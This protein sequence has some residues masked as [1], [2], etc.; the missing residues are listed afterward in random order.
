MLKRFI[1]GL[2]HFTVYAVG[3]IVLLAAVTVT[4]IRLVLPDIGEYR[5]EV[6]AWVSHYMG[7]P[8]VIHSMQAS[9]Q[10]WQP[11]LH[12]EDI[13]L[14]NKAGTRTITHFESAQVN[15]DPIATLLKRQF[16]PR[17]LMVSG[18]E[19]SVTRLEN[20][21]IYIQ[22][23]NIQNEETKT[24]DKNELAEWLFKQKKIELQNAQIEWVDFKH[25]QAPLLLSNVSFTLKTDA[26]RIQLE[27]STNLPAKYGKRMDF[28]FDAYGDLL[29][30]EWSGELYLSAKNINPDGWYKN[31]R[32]FDINIAGGKADLQVWSTWERAKLKQLEG[33][34]NY[35]DFATL[36]KNTSLHVEELSYGFGGERSSDDS[37][38]FSV[39]MDKFITEN[40]SWPQTELFVSTE[41]IQSKEIFKLDLSF[42]YLK[43]DDLTP[44]VSSLSLLPESM[45]KHLGDILI[46]GNLRNGRISFD[47]ERSKANK[48]LFELGFEELAAKVDTKLPSFSGLSGKIRGNLNEG[49]LTLNDTDSSEFSFFSSKK[50]TLKFAELDG[51]IS[52]KKHDIDWT[53]S[54][55]LLKLKLGDLSLRLTGRMWGQ[56]K[57]SAIVDLVAE[58]DPVLLEKIPTYL[59]DSNRFK[60]KQW[61]ERSILG[62]ELTSAGAIVRGRLS[63]FPFENHEGQFKAIAN[64]S[65]GV[66]EYSKQWPVVDNIDA[67]VIFAG[68]QMSGKFQHAKVFNADVVK[69]NAL[70][71]DL[72]VKNKSIVLDGQVK[73]ITKDLSLFIRQSPLTH[74]QMVTQTGD[75]LDKGDI[76]LDLELDI[77]LKRGPKLVGVEGKLR[78]DDAVLKSHLKNLELQAVKGDI[79]FTQNSAHG[80]NLSATFLDQAVTLELTK[81]KE[82]SDK[83]A[84]ISING[85]SDQ[86]FIISR[87]IEHVPTMKSREKWLADRLSGETDWQFTLNYEKNEGDD[88]LVNS[89][90]IRSNLLGLAIDLPEPVGKANDTSMPINV[91]K[92]LEE[93]VDST[94]VLQYGA[95]VACDFSFDR[96]TTTP[97]LQYIHLQLGE[98]KETEVI[99]DSGLLLSGKIERLGF[100]EWWNALKLEQEQQNEDGFLAKNHI[101]IDIETQSLDIFGQTFPDVSIKGKKDLTDWNLNLAAES[102]AGNIQLPAKLQRDKLIRF[103]LDKLYLKRTPSSAEKKPVDPVVVP[104]LQVDVKDFT[105]D[106]RV[107]GEAVLLA[108]PIED[109]LSIDQF[110]FNKPALAIQGKGIWR[111]HSEQHHSSFNIE[112][113]AD[114]MD[115]MLGTFGYDVTAIKKGETDLLI[116]ANWLGSPTDFSLDRLNGTLSMQIKKGQLLDINPSAGRLFGLLSIQTLPRRLSLDFTDLF[117]K[118]LA[119]DKIEGNFE[120]T[121]GNAYTNDLF[122][123]GPSA[124]V[125]ISG[126]TGLSEQDYDQVVTVTP[127]ITGN[128]PVAGALF[129]PVG[130]GLGAILYFASEMF[131]STNSNFGKLLR[132]QYTITGNWHEPVVEKLKTNSKNKSSG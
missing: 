44:L 103:D 100:S 14:L 124:S 109:G 104:S 130:I 26:E 25:Q 10:G 49:I 46:S 88:K 87:I 51:D 93:N 36:V 90:N 50:Q 83:V 73:G 94:L 101:H 64:V 66:L 75:A 4:M 81:S 132:Y 58:A 92:R 98:K 95:D 91:Y 71:P 108:S 82:Q 22:G 89:F 65:G 56:G 21:A 16:I 9:W 131:E 126:R 17:H 40:G 19:L 118:G 28:A 69:A 105:Y 37:W 5:N 127:Q 53:L 121:N 31:Y 107:F 120:I 119:F 123:D 76:T 54:S 39:N 33:N 128:L 116:D 129:G 3:I 6:E 30:S 77:P 27:G 7:F 68:K 74:N 125:A 62:G 86:N 79:H 106:D 8:V 67:E 111:R 35:S 1:K 115:A 96:Q 15:I 12:L 78:L 48:L 29:T 99:V 55:P 13:D 60:I 11:H 70:I 97:A 122:M 32:P 63:D 72:G 38:H 18:F 57:S 24:N 52:W 102:V 85:H 42:N 45:K 61:M 110:S 43:L 112:L 34:L 84:A 23:I 2:Y 41:P 80:E 114:D 20:G 117:N 47:P 59:P 113:H